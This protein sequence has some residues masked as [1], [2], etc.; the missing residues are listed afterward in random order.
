MFRKP[1]SVR[2]DKKNLSKLF[3]LLI[4]CTAAGCIN[5]AAKPALTASEVIVFRS[6][7]AENVFCYSPALLV[8]PSGRILASFD[9]GGPGAAQLP[10]AKTAEYANG[11]IKFQN[12]I[13]YS[14]DQGRS[15][16]LADSLPML[17]ARFFLDGNRI[18]II[19]HDKGIAISVS[20]D[21]GKHWS[22]V[23][24]LDNSTLWHQ[25]PC[26]I[27]YEDGYVFLTMERSTGP[28][29]PD[30][31]PVMLGGQLGKDLLDRKN[32]IFSNTLHYPEK[33]SSTLGIPFYRHGLLTPQKKDK[34]F[35][36]KPCYLESH[37]VKI[38]DKNHNLYE[39]NTLHVWMRQHSGLTNIAAMAKC[40][41]DPKNKILKMEFIRT[42][43][44]A[45]MLHTPFPGGH[46][47]FHV[48]YDEKSQYYWLVCTQSADS[49]TRPDA[50]P[51]DRYN[52]PD[53]ERHRLA[54]YFSKNMFDW[55]FAGMIANETN[56][57]CSRNYPFMA[58]SGNDLLI[59][60]RSG[61]QHAQS[62]HNGNLLTLHKVSDFRSLIY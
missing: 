24:I 26:A 37:V 61:D 38:H 50:L 53:N 55:C 13:M 35:C 21:E 4:I 10:G 6:P 39:K 42:P 28:S 18:Y 34:R 49:M 14:D 16:T 54:L 11:R 8:L 27:H 51:D 9:L 36:G 41:F 30:V 57:K 56:P 45:L 20:K 1:F 5:Q 31:A 43:A 33:Q 3:F 59:F 48:V 60:C 29:W 22:P 47:K 44:D 32:W 62:A 25:A 46:L 23:K 15:W 58:V 7:A 40:R 17:H 19:G 2:F 52:L 12:R